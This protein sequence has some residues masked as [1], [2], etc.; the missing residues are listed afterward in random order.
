MAGP[1]RAAAMTTALAAIVTFAASLLC[2]AASTSAADK[3]FVPALVYD[4]GGKA[5]KSFNEA[6]YNGAERFRHETDI[7]YRDFEVN[8]ESQREQAMTAMVRRGALIV[9]AVG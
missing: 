8:N 9:V 7:A 3:P 5:D 6:A 1:D 4:I 2:G